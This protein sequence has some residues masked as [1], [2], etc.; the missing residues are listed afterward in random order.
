MPG[1]TCVRTPRSA[2]RCGVMVL[3]PRSIAAT[4]KRCSPIGSTTY[5]SGVVTS[6]VKS[7]PTISGLAFTRCSSAAGSA[8]ADRPEKIPT[9]IAPR[10]RRCRVRA[11]VSMP[12]IPT[13]PCS[14]SSWSRLRRERQ[15]DG[16]RAGSRTT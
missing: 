10:S 1:S 16:R 12:L 2:S 11:L 4:V 15:L 13:T 9:R 6:A 7:A 3:M 14:R 8:C 5:G